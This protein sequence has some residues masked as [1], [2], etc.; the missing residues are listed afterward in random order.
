LEWTV[1]STVEEILEVLAKLVRKYGRYPTVSEILIEKRANA[2]IPTPKALNRKVG[3]KV[4]TIKK[5]RDYCSSREEYVDVSAILAQVDID[6]D[7]EDGATESKIGAGKT[8][9]SGHVYLVKSGRFYKIG[10]TANRWQRMNQLDKQT[11]EGIDEVIH[12][13]AAFDDAPGIEQYWHKR[14][15][16]KCVKGEWFD[17]SAEDIRAFKKRKWM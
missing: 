5:L 1:G 4:E 6:T 15:E 2:T 17:L 3:G 13:I 10:Q 9:P 8:K 16:D 12:T 11:S 14:F 7:S